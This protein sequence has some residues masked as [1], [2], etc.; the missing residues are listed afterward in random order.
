MSKTPPKWPLKFLRWYCRED[1]IDEIEGDL[2][3]LFEI[4]SADS[5]SRADG[6]FAWDVLKS[7]RLR[8]IKTSKSIQNSNQLTMLQH[9]LKIA[10]RNLTKQKMYSSIKVGGFAL[11]IAA[12]FL[13]TLFIVDE[14]SYDKHYQKGD[15]IYRLIN[16]ETDPQDFGKW[17]FF[18]AQIGE[19]LR[20]DFPEIENAGRMI[21]QNWYNAG[22]N[23]LKVGGDNQ[24]IYEEG[25]AYA[26]QEWLDILEIPMVYG[27]AAHALSEPN[28][29]VL[30]KRKADKYFPDQDPVGKSIFLNNDMSNPFVIGG[31]MENFPSNSHFSSDFL[32]TLT[33]VEFWNGEQTS[34][35]CSNYQAYLLVRPGTDI[36]SLEEKLLAIR[37]NYLLPHLQADGDVYADKLQQ[38]RQYELQKVSDIHLNSQNISDGLHHSDIK[39]VWL[40]GATSVFILLLA[41]INFINLS[42]A[43]SANRAKEVGLRK[44]VGSYRG[45]LVRQFMT[46]SIVFSFFSLAIGILLAWILLPYFNLLAD[47]TLAFPWMEWWLVPM[48]LGSIVVIG[49]FSGVY[50]SM[51]LSKFK[52]IDVLSGAL[53]RGSK[54]SKLRSTMVIFQFATSIVLIIC[55]FITYQQMD[56]LLH[57]ELG[58]SKEQVVLIQGA[59]TLGDKRKVL[60][61]ELLKLASVDKVTQSNYLPVSGTK[62]D[63]NSF[64]KEGR[65]KIDQGVSAQKWYV[66]EDYI[67]ALEMK[68][69]AGRGFSSEIASDSAAIIINQ[70]MAKELG[71]VEPLGTRIT[72]E[73]QPTF[74]VIGVLEDF[75]F[76]SMKRN[77]GALALVY[78]QFGSIVSVKVNAENMSE[79]LT[80]M[81]VLWESVMPDQ[82]IRYTFL[83]Q[84][85]AIMYEDVNRTGR[86]FTAF[87]IL[88]IVVACLGLFAL[89]AFMVEQR[90]K[91]ISIRKVLGAS[92]ASIFNLLTLDFL[93]LV[94]I[95]L[96]I[97]VPIGWYLMKN[98]LDDYMYSIEISWSV[99]V[100][101]G[102]VAIFIAV[103]TISLESIKAA[104]AN[105]A[106]MLRSE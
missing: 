63:Q 47:K 98:W 65:S 49:F 71:L 68:L 97:A 10:W 104:I 87:S 92:L 7:F 26:D 95:A 89:S 62:R 17:T 88:A 19:V 77:L 22:S 78:S 35:C 73:F 81:T 64:W 59:N 100:F 74:H 4:R 28:S 6:R 96:A 5:K 33:D 8:N 66:D 93:K 75:H 76:E 12:C 55:T 2:I 23:Q 41:C 84:S 102:L 80:E 42:T 67:D 57:T 52:P 61:E 32:I 16:V 82:P 50:P 48:L 83:D 79:T 9:Y 72:N 43:K 15:R 60:K 69:V 99:F 31:V 18:Q 21:H 46:E 91:E 24:S 13:I 20:N 11:G 101:S 54:S 39:I 37:D 70:T 103:L 105:P 94:L 58:Y 44:V 25:F 34:W 86:I 85:Y 51:Y 106:D 56:F 53:V 90:G 38:Y 36:A 40:F 30:S 27:D 14:L 29:I 3:E 1:Y 45:N